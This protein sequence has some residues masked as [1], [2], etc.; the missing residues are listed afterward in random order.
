MLPNA[1]NYLTWFVANI[2]FMSL[3]FLLDNRN[4]EKITILEEKIY[5]QNYFHK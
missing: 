3:Y 4:A 1:F 2:F 5:V